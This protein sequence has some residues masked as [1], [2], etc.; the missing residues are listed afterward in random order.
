MIMLFVIAVAVVVVFGLFTWR[1]EVT[2]GGTGGIVK[3][4]N[5]RVL[6]VRL[7]RREAAKREIESS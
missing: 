3:L 7:R 2:T 1:Y 5:D 6:L 4:L